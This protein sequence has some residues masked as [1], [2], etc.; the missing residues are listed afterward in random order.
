[1]TYLLVFALVLG[2]TWGCW[3]GARHRRRDEALKADYLDRWRALQAHPEHWIHPAAMPPLR[4]LKARRESQ[5]V[6]ASQG[7]SRNT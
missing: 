3:L 2:F 4:P 7:R 1:M 5:N 6:D